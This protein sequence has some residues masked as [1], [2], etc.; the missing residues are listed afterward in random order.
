MYSFV[1]MEEILKSG[2]INL[3]ELASRIYPNKTRLQASST[4]R[5]KIYKQSFN[6]LSDAEK[7]KIW[8]IIYQLSNDMAETSYGNQ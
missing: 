4:I 2:L 3:T 8:Q 5:A 6:K 1:V 7:A